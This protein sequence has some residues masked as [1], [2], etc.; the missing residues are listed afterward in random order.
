[1]RVVTPDGKGI[2]V[3]YCFRKNTNGGPGTKQYLVKLAD[4]R[5]RRYPRNKVNYA[6]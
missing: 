6:H 5:T 3:D 1:M 2:I 4:N